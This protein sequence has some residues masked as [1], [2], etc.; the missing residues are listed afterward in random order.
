MIGI[1]FGVVLPLLGLW[2]TKSAMSAAAQIDDELE[3]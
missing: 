3:V 2:M 1:F